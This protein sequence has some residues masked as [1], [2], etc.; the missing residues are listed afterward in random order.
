MAD[1]SL[2]QDD[3]EDIDGLHDLQTCP[4]CGFA[5]CFV[6]VNMKTTCLKCKFVERH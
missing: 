5:N 1:Y 4:N 6:D 3:E 2:E